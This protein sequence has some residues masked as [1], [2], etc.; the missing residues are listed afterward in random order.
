MTD[1]DG[2]GV[3]PAGWRMT[4]LGAITTLSKEKVDPRDVPNSPYLGLE[5]IE[6]S[7]T[8][9][10]TGRGRGADVKSAK[11]VFRPDDVLYGKLRPYLNKVAVPD[12]E[13]ICSTDILVLRGSQG[14]DAR[15]LAKLV[16][17]PAF[18]DFAHRASNGVELPRVNWKALS[19]FELGLPPID[20][21]RRIAAW[22]DQMDT[23]RGAI[24]NRLAAARTIVEQLRAAVLAAACSGRLTADWRERHSDQHLEP[25]APASVCTEAPLDVPA[26][27]TQLSLDAAATKITSGPRDWSPYYDSGSATFVMAQNVRP[28]MMDW[29]FR[30]A[31]DP[32]VTDPSRRRCQIEKGDVLV[33]IVGANTGDVAPVLENRPEHFVCQSVALV[34][35]KWPEWGLF[36]SHWFNSMAHGGGYFEACIYGAGRPHLSFDQLKRAPLALPPLAE[37][38]EIGKRTAAAL[39]RADQLTAAID[40]AQVALARATR[41]ALVR[42]FRGQAALPSVD[43]A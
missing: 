8:L 3:L 36:L 12:F 29:S 9:R 34:R 11:N 32:P 10:V 35:P 15:F 6:G 28:G 1:G 40:A 38:L 24:A 21:Q 25:S 7:G 43:A 37:Q 14:L 17:Q 39:A 16:S 41:S 31:V 13:G 5:H 33:T 19:E 30:Q 42:A 26:T 2:A 18:V 23:R 22:L 4:K 20:E 27:W